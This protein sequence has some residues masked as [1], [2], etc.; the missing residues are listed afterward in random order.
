ME[1]RPTSIRRLS[2]AVVRV[3]PFA[4][5]F[6]V[7]CAP[8][9]GPT[10][11]EAGA[12]D[13][14]AAKKT[15]VMADQAEPVAIAERVLGSA[16]KT[17]VK[18]VLHNSLVAEY[19][20]D[21]HT[22]QIAVEL[23]SIENG[24]WRINLDRTMDITWKL[25]PNVKWHDGQPFTAED[26]LFTLQVT[27]DP[28]LSST[29]GTISRSIESATAPDP[30]TFVVHWSQPYVQAN[31]QEPWDILPKHLL[32]DTY[33]SDRSS[34]L[35]SKYL[36]TEFIGLGPYRLLNW[37]PGSHIEAGRFDA[38][39]QGRPS[40]DTVIVR[41]VS[42]ANTMVTNILAGTVDVVLSGLDLDAAVEIKRR[43]EGT[44]NQ[45][46]A[47]ETGAVYTAEPQYR[48]D[49]ARPRDAVANLPVR[50]ALYRAIDRATLTEVMTY[51]LSPVADSYFSP[52][53]PLRPQ[54]ES[55]IPQ[56]AFDPA[57]AGRQLAEA[58][59]ARGSDGAL[60][61]ATNGDRFEVDL[62]ARQGPGNERLITTAADNWKAI[63]VATTIQMEPAALAGS[64]E[65]E[66][67]RPGFLLVNASGTAYF[68]R[69]K[70]HSRQIPSPATRW[71][72]NN[73]GG[74]SNAKVDA[75]ID[76]LNATIDPRQRVPIHQELVREAMADLATFPLFWKVEPVLM[77][78]GVEGPRPRASDPTEN[79]FEWDLIR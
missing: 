26:M 22:P 55:F 18:P 3:L 25:R 73:F 10:K 54:L 67:Q 71:S 30:L 31:W 78:Q 62:W 8:A 42:D 39:F 20:Y 12:G 21:V 2:A 72:G 14:V 6:A 7:S 46:L 76:R 9:A 49:Y 19:E 41:F 37:E 61:R 77:L 34:F 69:E 52:G 59:W 29:Q 64:R 57:W 47:I 16:K 50:Q 56:Y 65:Y 60:A 63:G 44:G 53:D 32:E 45:V 48:P 4:L 51:G 40:L 70:L 79:M 11:G 75:L 15:L 74:Y 68:E 33:L 23:P 66:S 17:A 28:D 36:T 1:P 5:A 43:W 13:T 27:K 58:G 24:T 38:Y 35:A